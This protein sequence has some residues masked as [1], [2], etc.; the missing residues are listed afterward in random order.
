M[1]SSDAL[2]ALLADEARL[3]A[4]LTAV[5]RAEQQA[6]VALRPDVVFGCLAQRQALAEALGEVADRRRALVR[7][8]ADQHGGDGESV[9]AL[10]ARLPAPV[11]QTLR[12]ALRALRT[13]LLEARGLERQ[14]ARLATASLETTHE[15]LRALAAL[16]PGARYG[17]DAR[18]A[19]P[20][21]ERVARRA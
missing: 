15:I 11:Q 19:T 9:V 16:V 5:L 4:E 3:C 6:L 20:A 10:I 14:N 7:A 21:A 8:L 18:L 13:A 1:E 12:P 2:R 17:A